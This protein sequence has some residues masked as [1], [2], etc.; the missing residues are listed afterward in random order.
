MSF[1]VKDDIPEGDG[2]PSQREGGPQH[3]VL[4]NKMY[5]VPQES[6]AASVEIGVKSNHGN[7]VA[8]KRVGGTRVV[9]YRRMYI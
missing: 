6:H 9:H 4:G 8:V 7:G 1:V 3:A 2:V 5:A